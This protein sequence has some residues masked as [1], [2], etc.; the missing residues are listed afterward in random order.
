M[1]GI[2]SYVV[3]R[4]L[5][6]I[7]VLIGITLLVFLITAAAGNPIDLIR[8][9]YVHWTPQIE[10]YFITYYHL[11]Q[12]PIVRYYY[13][14]INLLHLNLGNSLVS[15]RPVIQSI[16]PWLWTTFYLQMSALIL[17]MVI[18]VPI[19]IYSAKHQYAKSDYAITGVAIFG[20][21]MPTFWLGII[22][23]YVFAFYF[24]VLPY[25]GASGGALTTWWGGSFQDTVAH[26]ILPMVTLAYVELATFV[27]LIRGNML[28]V[29]RQDY[30]LAAQASGLSD[31]AV[32]YKHALK[33]A[34]T[35]VITLVGL[36]IGS[37]LGGAPATE[38]VF[39]WPGLGYAFTN[40]ALALDIPV[41]E[42][43]TIVITLMVLVANLL[44]DLIYGIVDPRV[45]VS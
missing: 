33:N 20:F 15:G 22:L 32:T 8:H 19:G 44:L 10:Q 5:F 25:G 2:V 14:L 38:T 6:M 34:I 26:L 36:T 4:V 39:S 1:A 45:R 27:R 35:P 28:E 11:D 30:V 9:S 7:P 42:A 41:I 37:A 29:L 40:A 21:S 16:G 13:Y 31:F 3:R 17:S 12:S 43:L 24:R 18:G 23:I